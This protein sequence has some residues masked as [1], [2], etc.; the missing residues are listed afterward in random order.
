MY[1]FEELRVSTMCMNV[2]ENVAVDC[3]NGSAYQASWIPGR[4]GRY[5]LFVYVDSC[6][7]GELK[8]SPSNW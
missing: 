7:A 6:I 5:Q 2:T 8:L 3:W 4:C 1:S